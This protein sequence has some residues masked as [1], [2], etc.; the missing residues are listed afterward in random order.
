MKQIRQDKLN[1]AIREVCD[2]FEK[3]ELTD[4][5]IKQITYCIYKS[6]GQQAEKHNL[7]VK[8]IRYLPAIVSALAIIISITSII[9]SLLK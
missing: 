9:A 6:I 7:K 4:E 8:V 5:E 3:S 2:V 1:T